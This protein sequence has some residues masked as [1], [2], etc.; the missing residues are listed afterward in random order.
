MRAYLV[1]NG[2]AAFVD[3]GPNGA[4]P[5]L[6]AALGAHGLARDAVEWVIPTHVHLDHAGG[7]GLLM[8]ELPA[9]KL[10]LHPRGARHMID[11]TG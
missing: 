7:V 9:A 3:T 4:V 6:L 11:P 1:E 5:R 10:V 2:R 8:R